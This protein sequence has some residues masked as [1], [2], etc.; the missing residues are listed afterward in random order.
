MSPTSNAT[1]DISI[2]GKKDGRKETVDV[3]DSMSIEDVQAEIHSVLG[4]KPEDQMYFTRTRSEKPITLESWFCNGKQEKLKVKGR[5]A[6]KKDDDER[7]GRRAL[8][9]GAELLKNQ[10]FREG[11]KQGVKDAAYRG[12]EMLAKG[13]YNTLGNNPAEEPFAGKDGNPTRFKKE[14]KKPAQ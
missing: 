9:K 3:K 13:T 11:A 5:P 1:N 8:Q 6:D 7:S 14:N 10:E 12:G 4:I 2:T